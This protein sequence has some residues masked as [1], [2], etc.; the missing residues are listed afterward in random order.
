LNS[1]FFMRKFAEIQNYEISFEDVFVLM[2]IEICI[3]VEFL[4]MKF[5]NYSKARLVT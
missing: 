2:Q 1:L 5:L 4:S 3:A